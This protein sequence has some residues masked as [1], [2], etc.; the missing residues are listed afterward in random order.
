MG[1][2]LL[3]KTTCGLCA[4]IIVFKPMPCYVWT[5]VEFKA[6]VDHHK[7]REC[8][9][10]ENWLETEISH[11]MKICSHACTNTLERTSMCGTLYLQIE[12]PEI[13]QCVVQ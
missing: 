1:V 10:V 9:S 11:R 13:F 3:C 4:K 8:L 7:Q 2:L 5:L 6:F 12:Q